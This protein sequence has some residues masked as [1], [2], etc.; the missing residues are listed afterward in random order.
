M[1]LTLTGINTMHD[2]ILSWMHNITTV[3]SI[4]MST[5]AS[6]ESLSADVVCLVRNI[7]IIAASEEDTSDTA[8]DDDND[9]D[10]K[11]R[12]LGILPHHDIPNI[13]E[14]ERT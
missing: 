5:P 4:I 6:A 14:D 12:S 3:I 2:I 10:E 7:T 11:L 9:N 8:H 1:G 13:Q